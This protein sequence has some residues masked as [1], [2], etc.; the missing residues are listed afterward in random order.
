MDENYE[1][2][3]EFALESDILEALQLYR[4]GDPARPVS[5]IVLR[6][7]ERQ[8]ECRTPATPNRHGPAGLSTT[9]LPRARPLGKG[10]GRALWHPQ[11]WG[12]PRGWVG[13]ASGPDAACLLAEPGGG[14][15]SPVS[16]V[17]AEALAAAA[18]G[19]PER[20]RALRQELAA[21]RHRREVARQRLGPRGCC[22]ERFELA[23]LL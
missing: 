17:S 14:G 12:W 21:S 3:A 11:P 19:P 20:S 6:D 10:G 22:A 1:W 15:S 23:T 13:D 18:G 2:D 4:S 7:L 9:L 16:S 8:S 5:T